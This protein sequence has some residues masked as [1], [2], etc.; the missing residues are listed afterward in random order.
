MTRLDIFKEKCATDPFWKPLAKRLT[1]GEV[2][3]A[4]NFLDSRWTL[5][6]LE[7]EYSVTRMFL[8]Q[9]NKPKNWAIIQEL[10]FLSNT[11]WSANGHK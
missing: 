10:L 3:I 9:P 6:H 11:V 5:S 2:L 4:E 1:K 7:F 8:D